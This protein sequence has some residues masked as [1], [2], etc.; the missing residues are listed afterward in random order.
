MKHTLLEKI[1]MALYSILKV[2][3]DLNAYNKGYNKKKYQTYLC[4]KICRNLV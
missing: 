3:I 1:F 2:R 4:R